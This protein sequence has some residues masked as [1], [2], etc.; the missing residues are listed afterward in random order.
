MATE[1]EGEEVKEIVD[2]IQPYMSWILIALVVYAAY[3]W[4]WKPRNSAAV[5][6]VGTP[7]VVS[8]S[9]SAFGS[10]AIGAAMVAIAAIIAIVVIAIMQ[11]TFPSSMSSVK[12]PFG[13]DRQVA[14]VKANLL[15]YYILEPS[16]DASLWSSEAAKAAAEATTSE[17]KLAVAKSKAGISAAEAERLCHLPKG[18]ADRVL[19]D[20]AGLDPCEASLPAGMQASTR[21]V[22]KT[23]GEVVANVGKLSL[24]EDK[25]S[26]PV[27][28]PP[29]GSDGWIQ[30]IYH[31][32]L[33]LVVLLAIGG[34]G[35]VFRIAVR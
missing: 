12:G 11:P 3:R 6:P 26:R 15:E 10:V 22:A 19:W 23:T 17:Y 27:G 2:L 32:P 1:E 7:P 5:A 8:A 13:P 14:Q 21:A 25:L 9:R 28:T 29:A 35:I 24:P 30:S 16:E 33:G 20:N 34:L 4:W 18:H 31:L